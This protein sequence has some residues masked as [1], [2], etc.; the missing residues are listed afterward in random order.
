MPYPLFKLH[1]LICQ[2]LQQVLVYIDHFLRLSQVTFHSVVLQMP[3]ICLYLGLFQ[4]LF[5]LVTVKFML[6][7]LLQLLIKLLH[8]GQKTLFLY[9]A[10]LF[11]SHQL[12]EI[13]VIVFLL[14][15]LLLKV[16][17]AI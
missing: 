9:E 1:I 10:R 2:L 14:I 12:A 7:D 15:E 4:F 17:Y 11:L 6:L 16:L 8:T 13:L 3:P 5:I